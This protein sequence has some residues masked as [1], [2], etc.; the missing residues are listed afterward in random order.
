MMEGLTTACT[1]PVWESTNF[2]N[3][4]FISCQ[5][6]NA[7]IGQI[8]GGVSHAFDSCIDVV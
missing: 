7:A 6:T 2:P 4:T 1:G 8:D 3:F 5:A